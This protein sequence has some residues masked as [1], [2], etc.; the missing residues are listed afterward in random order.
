[1]SASEAAR[2]IALYERHAGAWDRLRA[3]SLFERAWLDRFLGLVR[4]GGTVLDLGCGAGEPIAAYVVQRGFHLIGVDSSP[5]MIATARAR[6]P[7][8]DWHVADMRA[9]ALGRRCDGI[10]AW[11]SFFHLTRPDQRAM[12]PAFAAHAAAGAALMFTSGPS[13]GE[14]MG[15][16][17]GEPLYHASLAPDAYRR[18]LAEAGFAV[19]ETVA[20]DPA[21]GGHTVWLARR[22]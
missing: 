20:E 7:A 19:V 3:R 15:T 12:F 11:D 22:V 13:D 8:Q 9:L 17:E 2:I 5:A 14:A 6:M 16:F 4:P 21:C 18:D 10:L 1:V